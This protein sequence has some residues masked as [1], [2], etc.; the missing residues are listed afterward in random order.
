MYRVLVKSGMEVSEKLAVQKVQLLLG[1]DVAEED[2]VY[3]SVVCGIPTEGASS[4]ELESKVGY[5][6]PTSEGVRKTS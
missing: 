6:L 2:R 3:E 4:Q 1:N 5:C